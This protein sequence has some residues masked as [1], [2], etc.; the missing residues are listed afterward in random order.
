[1]TKISDEFDYRC[2]QTRTTE[3]F[4]LELESSIE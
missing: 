4:A 3:L 2:N 1:M